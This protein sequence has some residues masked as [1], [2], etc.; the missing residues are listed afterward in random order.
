ML[1]SGGWCLLFLA[2]SYWWIDIRD[3]K[4]GLLFFLIFGMNSIFIYLFFEIVAAR[5]FNGYVQAI[6]GGLLHLVHFPEV[7]AAIIG[8]L[9]IFVLEFGMLYFLYRK[10]V[11]FKL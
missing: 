6:T 4:K 8:S 11:F 2:L 10:K 1:T 7:P 9:A 5:W 3:H